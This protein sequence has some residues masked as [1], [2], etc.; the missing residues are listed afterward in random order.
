MQRAQ[1]LFLIKFSHSIV[2]L[3]ESAAILYLLYCALTGTT[4]VWLT[5]AIILVLLE[6]VVFV[7]NGQ[8]CPMTALAQRLGDPTGDDLIADIFLPRWFTPLVTPVCGGLA[9]VGFALLLLHAL[10]GITLLG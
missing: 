6:T 3:I 10:L 2:F 1:L 8:R 5:I 9:A 7:G 4:G